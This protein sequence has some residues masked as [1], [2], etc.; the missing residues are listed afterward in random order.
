MSLL[1]IWLFTSCVRQTF[2]TCYD[3]GS[4]WITYVESNIWK[5]WAVRLVSILLVARSSVLHLATQ[6]ISCIKPLHHV[7]AKSTLLQSNPIA[8]SLP[9]HALDVQWLQSHNIYYYYSNTVTSYTE[10]NKTMENTC[11]TGGGVGVGWWWWW[12]GSIYI[13]SSVWDIIICT[14]IVNSLSIAL[15]SIT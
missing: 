14:T 12:W 8:C 13:K 1:T 5:V 10:S 4:G 9:E 7:T 11:K 6:V 3:W 15:G 2:Q